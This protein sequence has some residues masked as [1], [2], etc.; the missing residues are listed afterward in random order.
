MYDILLPILLTIF[1]IFVNAFFVLAE[2]SLIRVRGSRLEEL[3]RQGN[4][5]AVLVQKAQG[6][7]N[8]YLAAVQLGIT[9]ASLVIGWLGE[10]AFEKV[11]ES[12]LPALNL[13]HSPELAHALSFIFAFSIITGLHIV[14]GEQS[15]KLFAIQNADR[16][17]MMTI[18]P[19]T[20]FY[21]ATYAP[22]WLLD[23]LATG[24]A[25]ML[26]YRGSKGETLH[27]DE[28]IRILL[29]EREE[30]GK[31][32][33]DRLMMFENLFDFG[34]AKVRD[35]MIPRSNVIILA[36]DD[37]PAEVL[38]ILQE[39]R[40]S[41]FPICTT[42]A[43]GL[44]S[45][46]GYLHVK[47]ALNLIIDKKKLDLRVAAKQLKRIGEDVS[48]EECLG[49]FQEKRVHLAL[50]VNTEGTVTGLVAL[51][52]L[53]EEIVG[54]IRDEYDDVPPLRL[55]KVLVPEAVRIAL[56]EAFTRYD[57]IRVMLAALYAARPVF[58][59]A[60]AETGVCIREKTLTTAIGSFAAIPHARCPGIATP[61]VG[62]ATIPE[63]MEWNA[64][65]G[66]AVRVVFL[67][68][69]PI[70]MPSAQVTI[71][72]GLARVL[73][74]PTLRDRLIEAQSTADVMEAVEAAEEKLPD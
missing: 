35:A 3:V 67:I 60:A 37:K 9:M 50:V 34:T 32:S 44:D 52:D 25:R 51:E 7:L 38:R 36:L 47:D 57:V 6:N 73:S 71:L 49:R 56:P 70:T 19:L 30:A 42:R 1:F 43:E 46:I 5:A 68:L 72:A 41:R 13:D 20:V 62:F 4:R 74:T 45:V 48:L 27:S 10:P 39:N 54:E 40:Y 8:A 66:Q 69:T 15:P 21:Y 14:F 26:G 59:L 29:D 65:D 31:L 16:I 23:T 58:D 63:G 33:L 12:I 24:V 2:F 61:L 18:Y 64:P 53:V 11:V 28:E 17:S 22:M 55:S